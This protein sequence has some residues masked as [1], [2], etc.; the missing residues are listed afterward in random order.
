M[1]SI[2][3]SRKQGTVTVTADNGVSRVWP[4]A[5]FE[6]NP[7]AC[8]A[9]TGNG[10]TPPVVEPTPEEKIALLEK[11]NAALEAALIEK[12]ILTKQEVDAKVENSI[13]PKG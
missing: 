1:S 7:A 2:A 6:A 10:I 9:Q 11:R 8:V 5:T 4:L 13:S 3:Y 12:A